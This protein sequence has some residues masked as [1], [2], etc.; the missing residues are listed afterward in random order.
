MLL[1]LFLAINKMSKQSLFNLYSNNLHFLK[2]HGYLKNTRL[3]FE[4]TFICPICLRQFSESDL[5]S[6]SPNMLTIEHAPPESLGG[7]G[8]TMTCKEC[9][10]VAGT[11]IDAHLVG[12]LRELDSRSF[13]PNTETRAKITSGGITIQGKIVRFPVW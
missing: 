8:G 12:R 6:T 4:R 10:S 3:K 5:D 13:L 9:N 2:E 11:E 1:L 7:S